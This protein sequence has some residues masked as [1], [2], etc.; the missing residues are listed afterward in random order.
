MNPDRRVEPSSG[1]RVIND[2]DT[3][4]GDDAI[5]GDDTERS[6]PMQF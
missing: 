4:N 1:D 2:D 3:I 6:H 5:D